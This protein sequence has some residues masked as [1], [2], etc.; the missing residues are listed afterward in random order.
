M[1][2]RE[3]L[4]ERDELGREITVGVEREL[5]APDGTLTMERGERAGASGERVMFLKNDR[6]LGVKNGSLGRVLEIDQE[7]ARVKLDGRE[8]R[9]IDFNFDDYASLDYGYAA[10]VHKAQGAT[11]E[12]SFVLATPGMDRHL[13]YVGLT[14]HREGVELFAGR[15][16]FLDFTAL[17]GAAQPGT[18]QGLHAGLRPAA[19]ARTGSRKHA[20]R[21]AAGG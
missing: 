8:E 17:E 19:R 15:D 6:E 3:I 12:R 14:R 9:E 13:A 1:S 21:P 4:K 5:M 20:V 11:V 7:H 10:T 2:G 16:D 18:A